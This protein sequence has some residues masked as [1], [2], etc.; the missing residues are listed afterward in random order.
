MAFRRELNSAV[1]LSNSSHLP[2]GYGFLLAEGLSLTPE[3]LH[4]SQSE[5]ELQ[6]SD[7]LLSR[8]KS[9]LRLAAFSSE[10]PPQHHRVAATQ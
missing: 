9:A 2:L 6:I 5:D 4:I 7:R 8:T 1:V 10:S 3:E